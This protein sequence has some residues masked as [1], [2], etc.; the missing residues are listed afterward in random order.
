MWPSE[1]DS[2]KFGF[3]EVKVRSV[4]HELLITQS[5]HTGLLTT[6][7]SS[8]LCMSSQ[9]CVSTCKI[10]GKKPQADDFAHKTI[11]VMCVF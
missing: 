7:M 9:L 11:S 3:G 2:K 4:L 5:V 1:M 6:S 8:G 10:I